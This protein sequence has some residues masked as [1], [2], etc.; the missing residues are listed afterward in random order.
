MW[1]VDEQVL[2]VE[3]MPAT[4]D[5][6]IVQIDSLR[7]DED[8]TIDRATAFHR[9]LPEIAEAEA[10]LLRVQRPHGGGRAVAAR[11]QRTACQV[12]IGKGCQHA[13]A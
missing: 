7:L 10:A 4:V 8:A 3:R 12:V 6:G 13:G 5:T 1:T 2:P 11:E 9:R